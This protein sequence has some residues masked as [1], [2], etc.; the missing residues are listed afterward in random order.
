VFTESLQ[1]TLDYFAAIAKYIELATREDD[2]LINFLLW[3]IK[4]FPLWNLDRHTSASQ[5]LD[6]Y[7]YSVLEGLRNEVKVP[8][9][10]CEIFTIFD[11][12]SRSVVASANDMESSFKALGGILSGMMRA[13]D[14]VDIRLLP[15]L[16]STAA[17][18]LSSNVFDLREFLIDVPSNACVDEVLQRHYSLL[19][20]LLA[21]ISSLLKQ[22]TVNDVVDG[23]ESV[24]TL[25]VILDEYYSS[26]VQFLSRTSSSE[27][28]LYTI[29]NLSS[30]ITI[31]VYS[32][33]HVYFIGN[34]MRDH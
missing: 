31:S 19:H 3:T 15:K 10:C 24:L 8:K 32:S 22:H 21:F 33:N 17:S 14:K 16:S 13:V 28:F 5:L 23:K 29:I 18:L 4:N 27:S 1:I 6:I 9:H 34:S 26:I 30:V 7:S 11:E 20:S 25:R 12:I 2:Q